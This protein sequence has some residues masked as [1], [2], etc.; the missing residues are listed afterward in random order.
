MQI[1]ASFDNKYCSICDAIT[2]QHC[3]REFAHETAQDTY[4]LKC[5][6]CENH[7]DHVL[8]ASADPHDVWNQ[9]IKKD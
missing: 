6:Q 7:S 5:T 8:V 2:E 3:E 4:Y 9:E 1:P